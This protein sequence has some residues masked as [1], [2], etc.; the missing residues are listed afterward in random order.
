[1]NTHED[2]ASHLARRVE[3]VMTEH[4]D[5]VVKDP[6]VSGAGIA[7]RE[8]MLKFVVRTDSLENAALLQSRLRLPSAIQ[9][10]PLTFEVAS[11]PK[12]AERSGAWPVPRRRWRWLARLER[13]FFPQRDCWL[14]LLPHR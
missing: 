11:L 1:M 4:A 7:W 10:F 8:G 5:R 3:L 12:A 9:D 14:A 13:V 2:A 6:A